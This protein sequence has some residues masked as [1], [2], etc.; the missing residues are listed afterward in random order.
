MSQTKDLN[1]FVKNFNNAFMTFFYFFAGFESM[2]S[3]SKNVVNPEKTV[4]KALIYVLVISTLIYFFESFVVIGAHGPVQADNKNVLN[5]LAY[6]ALGFFGILV[7]L[8]NSFSIKLNGSAQYSLY[9]G[10]NISV[11]AE[12]GYISDKL[13]EKDSP[14]PFKGALFYLTNVVIFSFILIIFPYFLGNSVRNFA[15]ILS[16]IVLFQLPLYFFALIGC[17]YMSLITKKMKSKTLE[18]II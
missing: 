3:V 15:D 1:T 11:L 6:R 14:F 13:A 8:I 18:I 17:L 2:A 4:K 16:F 7:L 10:N 9:A 12:E 5:T